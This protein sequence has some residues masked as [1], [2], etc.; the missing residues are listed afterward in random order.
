M[1]SPSHHH[2]HLDATTGREVVYCHACSNEWYR[3]ESGLI[4]PECEGE[5]TEIV[6]EHQH[7]SKLVTRG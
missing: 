4:C 7:A 6:S 2:G 5:I 1:E 3:D